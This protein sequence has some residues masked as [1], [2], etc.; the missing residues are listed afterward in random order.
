MRPHHYS[1]VDCHPGHY[2]P[3]LQNTGNFINDPGL[4]FGLDE[5]DQPKVLGDP[6]PR[7][8]HTCLHQF[9]LLLQ[10][11]APPKDIRC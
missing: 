1:A 10:R 7:A 9:L 2:H 11:Q 3:D 6:V 5:S 8:G 4:Q